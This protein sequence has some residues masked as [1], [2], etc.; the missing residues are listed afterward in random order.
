MNIRVAYY[1]PRLTGGA[2]ICQQIQI[3]EGLRIK[4]HLLTYFA[5]LDLYD[6][7]QTEN[8]QSPSVIRRTWTNSIL[9][10]LVQRFTWR[11]QQSLGI[12]YLNVF[13][14]WCVYDACMQCLPGYDLVQERNG[15]YKAGVAGACRRLGI[16]YILFFDADDIFELDY[17]GEPLKGILRWRAKSIIRF[18]LDT[19]SRIITVSDATK[20]RLISVWRIP[21][22]KIVVFPNSVDIH[23]FKPDVENR[24]RIR[25]LFG[26][27]NDPLIIFV[28]NFYQWHDV[29]TLIKAIPIAAKVHPNLHV[30]LVGDGKRRGEMEQLVKTLGLESIVTFTGMIPKNDVPAYL[31]AADIA[32]SPYPK[33]DEPWWGSSMKLFEY[34]ATGIAVVASNIG[35][36]VSEVI[37]DGVNGTLVAP[38]DPKTLG[39]TLIKLID[40]PKLRRRLGS[41]ARADAAQKYSLDSYLERLCSLYKLI[42]AEHLQRQPL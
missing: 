4:G 35:Y 26:F 38:E 39:E 21:A 22:E 17:L 23:L 11:V 8:L 13:S 42:L 28:G 18:T 9:F 27:G 25:A 12:P 16:P 31:N 6:T 32:V 41:C 36:Q 15:L 34:L 2:D 37:E 20:N 33:M 24:K 40:D 3:A 14:N 10:G 19:A 5:P 30:L 29:A 7:V 1:L